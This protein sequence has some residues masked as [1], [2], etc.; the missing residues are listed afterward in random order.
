M[1]KSWLTPLVSR[2]WLSESR[3]RTQRQATE[4]ARLR[5]GRP[6]ALH[7]FH[8]VDDPYAALLIQILPQ[9]CARYDILFVPHVV[10]P[11]DD[12]AAPERDALIA[13]SRRDAHFLAQ[14][15]GCWWDPGPHAPSA[16]ACQA[17]GIR[18]ARLATS[19]D[20]PAW[21]AAAQ[22]GLAPLW[23]GQQAMTEPVHAPAWQAACASGDRLRQRLGH[24][25]GAMLW[26]GGEWYWGL[27]RLHHLQTRLQALGL[28]RDG[29]RTLLGPA[30]SNPIFRPPSDP[31]S[32]GP[33]L[34]FFFSL[35]SPYSALATP[36]VLALARES[37]AQL[38]LRF[39][40]PMV[41]RGLPVPAAK[42]R[43]IALD[44][45]REARWHGVPFGCLQDPLGRPTERGLAVLAWAIGQGRGEA[46]LQGLMHG[47]WAQG[48]DIGR[49][50]PLRRITESAGLPWADARQALDDPSWRAQAEQNRQDLQALGLWGVPSF[51]T[52]T[53]AVWGQDRLT[54][55]R[56]ALWQ[57]C[58]PT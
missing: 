26:Y 35:R 36:R 11:P 31:A 50:A 41:M 58:K 14:A 25:L 8:Q 54:Q 12:A 44:A 52:Q 20:G 45:A 3:L 9:I 21:L 19:L 2:W 4:K 13:W 37:G 23:Q 46:M 24:Y 6:H 57:E 22:A 18:L 10:S 51:R 40:L 30:D 56:Q 27:D 16:Q 34:D 49:D 7:Y 42:R 1:L 17:E 43:Y 15:W 32:E 39:V 53:C 5:S 55:V 28:Q 29:Q 38:R 47:I 33:V 48:Q